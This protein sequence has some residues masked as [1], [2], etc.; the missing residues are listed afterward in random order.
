MNKNYLSGL[1]VSPDKIFRFTDIPQFKITHDYFIHWS[2]Y[3][4][5]SGE[6]RY[7]FEGS[8]EHRLRAGELLLVPP[9]YNLDKDAFGPITGY[10]LVYRGG[11]EIKQAALGNL[12]LDISP[13]IREDLN[14]LDVCA[15]T[16]PYYKLLLMDIWYQI[17]SL[18]SDPVIPL[19]T[20][21]H[22]PT[23]VMLL[24]YIESNLQNKL[25]LESLCACSGYSKSAL[26]SLFKERTKTT[27]MQYITSCRVDRAKC[28]LCES[29]RTIRDL[30]DACGFSNEFY[31]STVFHKYT[32]MSPSE[33]R[34]T[35]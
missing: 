17:C 2:A 19:G 12:V 15:Q 24:N 18:Y 25:T 32:G 27:P 23:F 26:I 5:L 22:Q 7:C 6:M 13:R 16:D 8:G 9:F 1:T 33:Y 31:F 20:A 11:Q 34:K 28:L 21:E 14:L 3:L 29:K 35:H 4:L 10:F 30:A